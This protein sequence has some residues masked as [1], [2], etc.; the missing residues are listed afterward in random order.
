MSS[1]RRRNTRYQNLEKVKTNDNCVT[2]YRPA[3]DPHERKGGEIRYKILQRVAQHCFVA[4]FESTF[5]VFN[6]RDQLVAQQKCSLI[7]CCRLKDVVARGGARV[8]FEQQI[9]ALLLVFHQNYNL[10]RLVK[11]Q[12]FSY[13]P[14]S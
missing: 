9:L 4:C 7:L 13:C 8:Y 10:W 14:T 2:N 5:R 6:M 11:Q 12:I 1:L 3:S